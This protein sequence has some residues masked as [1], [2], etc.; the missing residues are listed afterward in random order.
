[1]RILFRLTLLSLLTF[2]L[3]AETFT[4]V[5]E[6]FAPFEFKQDGQVV[7]ID[8]DIARHILTKL[9]IEP[10]FKIHPWKRAWSQVESGEVE[11]VFTTSRKSKREP[12]VMYPEEDMW[13]SDFVF[14]VKSDNKKEGFNGFESAKAENLKIGIIPGNS[15]K[16]IFWQT[17]PYA[18]GKA[19]F[20]GDLDTSST[21][22]KQL[23]TA[24]DLTTNLK[25]L[26]TGRVDLVIAD[27]TVGQYTAKLN[28]LSDQISFYEKPLY[29]KGYPMPFVKGS[30]YPNLANIAEKF[31]AELKKIKANGEYQKIMDKWLK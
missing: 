13:V 12:Y 22:N 1:M 9:G 2:N 27:R 7:G 26:A 11:A 15:Y 18:D 16:D 30:K 14:F 10:V 4:V 24:K 28:G 8:V 29:G 20:Q 19:E 21:Y 31:E 25:K 17:F 23:S 3:H 6:E 5:G